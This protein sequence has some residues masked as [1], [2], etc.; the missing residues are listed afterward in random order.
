MIS[1]HLLN[2]INTKNI[3]NIKINLILGSVGNILLISL[4]H[5]MM[6]RDETCKDPRNSITSTGAGSRH[7]CHVAA[8]IL[9]SCCI[10][11]CR[12]IPEDNNT[13]AHEATW[14][15]RRM[16]LSHDI[17]NPCHVIVNTPLTHPSFPTLHHWSSLGTLP[18]CRWEFL[19]VIILPKS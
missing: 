11:S 1:E 19:I 10:N 8:F 14:I 6:Q 4:S 16:M 17:T 18:I 12:P 9:Y 7:V 2:K 5:L 15:N 3:L 13:S